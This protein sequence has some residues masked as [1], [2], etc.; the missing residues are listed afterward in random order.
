M[1]NQLVLSFV[2]GPPL[3][4]LLACEG[5]IDLLMWHGPQEVDRVIGQDVFSQVQDSRVDLTA[6]F[7]HENCDVN[8]GVLDLLF[9]GLG[10]GVLFKTMDPD[11]NESVKAALGEGFAKILLLSE[12][13]PSIPASLHCLILVKLVNMYF[14]GENHELQRY[15]CITFMEI[16]SVMLFR[17]CSLPCHGCFLV[18]VPF[19]T[20]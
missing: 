6:D 5:L 2:K 14:S 3:V 20:G 12:N 11:E 4:S 19:F 17:L 13:Y 9:A 10:S 16:L 8:L 15:I 18:L 1:I 7:F